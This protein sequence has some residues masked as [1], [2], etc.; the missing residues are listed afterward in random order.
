[1]IKEYIQFAIDNGYNIWVFSVNSEDSTFV[2]S[3]SYK[4]ACEYRDKIQKNEDMK[5][6]VKLKYDSLE[7]YKII[8]SKPFIEA[9]ARGVEYKSWYKI[10]DV[11]MSNKRGEKWMTAVWNLQEAIYEI[12]INQA[13]AIRDW[14]LEEF[15]KDLLSNK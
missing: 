2:S 6:F 5:I 3:T 9:I 8:T 11:E 12:T 1:M 15:I 7:I 10:P 4:T 13:I 14:K